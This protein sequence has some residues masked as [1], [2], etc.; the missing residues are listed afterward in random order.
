MQPS[1]VPFN[2]CDGIIIPPAL[3]HLIARY[4]AMQYSFDY[5]VMQGRLYVKKQMQIYLL[6]SIKKD[7]LLF[8]LKEIFF[9]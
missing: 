4:L 2:I 7:L 8:Y 3:N 1:N 5:I 6:G 9:K